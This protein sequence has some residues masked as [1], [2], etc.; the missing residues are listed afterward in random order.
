M[1]GEQVPTGA[2]RWRDMLSGA[3]GSLPPALPTSPKPDDLFLILFTSG[4]TSASKG[5]MLTHRNIVI[6][7][8]Y[9][10]ERQQ[11]TDRDRMLIVLPLASAFS[12]AHAVVAT[13]GH[14][15]TLVL[16]DAFSPVATMELIE[17]ER[18][19]AMYGVGSMFQDLIDAPER[20]GYN[21]ATLRTG[22]GIL[23]PEMAQKIRVELGVPEYHNGWGMTE[24]GGVS[25]T[26]AITDPLE[27]RMSS[28]GTP[29]P[30]TELHLVDTTGNLVRPGEVGEIVLRGV[31][32]TA[33]YYGDPEATATLLDADGWLHTGD[34]ATLLPGG[35]VKY[36]GRAKDV[37]KTNGFS[38]A[39]LEI[40]EL[41]TALPGVRSAAVVGIPDA[42]LMEAVYAF[43]VTD[44]DAQNRLSEDDILGHC[45]QHLAG[46]KV[47]HHV[48]L[49]PGDLPRND[50][51]KV[52]KRELRETAVATLADRG[53]RR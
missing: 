29:M 45:R 46:Y 7:N 52:L 20:G 22:I 2:R 8:Y 1:L 40:E 11:L 44:P 48:Q 6:N 50:L 14:C 43:V 34:L 42:R 3:T 39:P 47:P 19:T 10:G 37:I 21:L 15:A 53:G 35:Y 12:C 51:G 30:G 13:L 17:R 26:T 33:G 28:I 23:T 31:S 16:L 36:V 18:C 4:T 27:I 41:L 9:S 25:T 32:I 24:S 38:V 49:L 5:V